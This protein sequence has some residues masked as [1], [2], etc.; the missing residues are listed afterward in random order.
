MKQRMG[1]S[2]SDSRCWPSK[3]RT[4]DVESVRGKAKAGAGSNVDLALPSMELP[5]L[6][7]TVPPKVVVVGEIEICV[8]V[9]CW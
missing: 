3:N 9:D 5:L 4:L 7:A 6:A 2:R 1:V 8:H